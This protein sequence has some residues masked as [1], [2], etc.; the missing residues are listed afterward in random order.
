M[1]TMIQNTLIALSFLFA[2]V[3]FADPGVGVISGVPAGQTNISC[4]HTNGKIT[5]KISEFPLVRVQQEGNFPGSFGAQTLH[6][7]VLNKDD[8]VVFPGASTA[9]GTLYLFGLGT[10]WQNMVKHIDNLDTTKALA[11]A[12]IANGVAT[13]TFTP[14]P[15]VDWYRL[16]AIAEVNGVRGWVGVDTSSGYQARDV[17]GNP[18]WVVGAT[19]KKPTQEV[20]QAV[21]ALK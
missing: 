8:F 3:S 7:D 10:D 1:K 2:G 4:T 18:L 11:S 5:L 6:N 20:L 9:T 12:K 13:V 17:D 16:N 19:C 14:K 15:K 21:A